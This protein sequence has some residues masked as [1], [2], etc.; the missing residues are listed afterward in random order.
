VSAPVAEDFVYDKNGKSYLTLDRTPSKNDRFKQ[1]LDEDGNVSYVHVDMSAKTLSKLG[2][3]PNPLEGDNVFKLRAA[4]NVAGGIDLDMERL[5]TQNELKEANLLNTL[6]GSLAVS[7]QAWERST[8]NALFFQSMLAENNKLKPASNKEV[9]PRWVVE[10][11]EDD[12]DSPNYVHPGQRLSLQDRSGNPRTPPGIK[13]SQFRTP[14]FWVKLPKEDT[15]TWGALAG[16]WISAPAY[17]SILDNYDT[18][19]K[20]R[21]G[22]WRDANTLWKKAVTVYRLGSH[23]LNLGGNVVLAYLHGIPA[24]NVRQGFRIVWAKNQ[25]D[26]PKWMQFVELTEQETQLLQEVKE[27]G[28][29]LASFKNAEF[30]STASTNQEA[31]DR[32]L[33]EMEKI[34][35]GGVESLL[36][37]ATAIENIIA[38]TEPAVKKVASIAK[39]ADN[40]ATTLYSEQDNIFRVAAYITS[41]QNAKRR[42]EARGEV[43]EVTAGVKA[44]AGQYALESFVNY[45]ISAPLI[46]NLRYGKYGLQLPFISWTYR[47][48]PLL[49]KAAVAAPWKFANLM[50]IVAIANALAYATLGGDDDREEEERKA[51]PEYLRSKMWGIGPSPMVRMPFVEKPTFLNLTNYMP[52]GNLFAKSDPDNILPDAFMFGGPALSILQ[53]SFGYDYFRDEKLRPMFSTDGAL[54]GKSAQF[55]AKQFTPRSIW[56]LG[57][58]VNNAATDKKNFFGRDPNYTIDVARALGLSINQ[59]DIG[60][61]RAGQ[62]FQI[63]KYQRELRSRMYELQGEYTRGGTYMSKEDVQRKAAAAFE[64]FKRK[65]KNLVE[66]R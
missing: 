34:N 51:M 10:S 45:N 66:G 50:A 59:Y 64:E 41:I 28:F 17:A 57:K 18:T 63:N 52:L 13:E 39:A 35:G 30:V 19:P 65:S 44:E 16:S 8:E 48:V 56:D 2:Y 53:W 42:A 25:Q 27:A 60:E 54:T 7:V 61:Q 38:A 36:N 31:I 40:I 6:I 58:I 29:E 1:V 55:L 33:K 26:L 49:A 12:V 32:S 3:V 11:L 22:L 14:G 20:I 47:M 23:A 15:A 37:V 4:R 9:D 5:R 24:E 43:F 46:D 21:E 62:A